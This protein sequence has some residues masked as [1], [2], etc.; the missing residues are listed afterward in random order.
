MHA[1]D[2]GN[3]YCVLRTPLLLSVTY[4]SEVARSTV[5]VTRFNTKAESCLGIEMSTEHLAT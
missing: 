3:L 2:F 4:I 1:R 5:W